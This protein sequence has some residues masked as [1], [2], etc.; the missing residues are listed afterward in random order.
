MELIKIMLFLM[1]GY[2]LMACGG[3]QATLPGQSTG[4]LDSQQQA[5]LVAAALSA[6]NGG[7]EEDIANVAQA[8]SGNAQQQAQLRGASLG[9]TISVNIDFYDEQDNPQ[10]FYDRDTTDRIDYQS[11][12]QG[13]ISNGPGFFSEFKI[14]NRS[15]FM[16][17]DILSRFVWINGSHINH[18]SYS[19]TQQLTQAVV[20]YQL[21]SELILN[22]V[23]VDLDASD[24]FPESGTIEGSLSGSYERNAL[25]G[26]QTSQFNFHFI[27]TY[28]GDNTAEVELGTGTTFIVQLGS[29]TVQDLE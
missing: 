21:D 8:A 9:Y 6:Q 16:V 26:Q 24:T 28:L 2:V 23:A 27:A 10:P 15:D 4:D 11:L 22:D 18:S 29:G 19:R 17:E 20:H 1:F 12:I 3:D 5:E 14:D 7:V 13:Q 25:T